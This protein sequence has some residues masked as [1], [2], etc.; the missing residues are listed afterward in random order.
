MAIGGKK[1][2]LTVIFIIPFCAAYGLDHLISEQ[3]D[4]ASDSQQDEIYLEEAKANGFKTQFQN[5]MEDGKYLFSF[6]TRVN[7]KGVIITG[8]FLLSTAAFVHFDEDLRDGVQNNRESLDRIADFFEPL[9]RPE[10]N[11]VECGILYLAARIS[12]D[13]YFRQTS[14]LSLESLIY[15][16]L[17]VSTSKVLFGRESP[18]SDE[19]WE[20]FFNG[21]NLFPSG[22][23]SRSFSIATVFAERYKDRKR[24][25][26]Y[27][28]YGTA[29]VIALSMVIN[30]THW[31]SDIFAGAALGILIGRTISKLN[32]ENQA[33]SRF[34]FTPS[35][36]IQS[37]NIALT[38]RFSFQ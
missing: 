3:D 10:I 6:P 9:G 24:I 15:T 4:R 34:T 19:Q 23:T 31:A 26:P 8:V 16:G 13:D 20:S 2:F 14:L 11:F 37:K 1:K 30:D 25:I 38:F 36:N 35:V 21:S 27:I 5:Y 22:H 18:S 12:D 7:R 33:E 17:I 28:A 29:S 32:S